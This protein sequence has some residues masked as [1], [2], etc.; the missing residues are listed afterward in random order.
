MSEFSDQIKQFIIVEVSPELKL[1]RI[2]DDEAL[3]ESGIV[4]SLGI[5]RILAFIDETF[6]VDLASDEIRLENFRTI[7]SICE[8][9]ERAQ[10][11]GA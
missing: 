2:S 3:L 5:L 11:A 6:G 7:R 9:I 8:L 10:G 1:Q 4:D